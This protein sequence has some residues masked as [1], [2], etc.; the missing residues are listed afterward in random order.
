MTEAVHRRPATGL[1]PSWA[2]VAAS[3]ALLA[4]VLARPRALHIEAGEHGAVHAL[5]SFGPAITSKQRA[6]RW[7][8]PDSVL[9][10]HGVG[11][12][13]SAVV[14][15]QA[16]DSRLTLHELERQ[17]IG[18]VLAATNGNKTEAARILGVDRTTLYRKLEEYKIKE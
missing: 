10:L 1:R 3:A 9:V 7:S 4:L 13:E 18:K 2:A 16:L 14:L 17:Y 5:R 11:A 12:G 8:G 6:C 15:S